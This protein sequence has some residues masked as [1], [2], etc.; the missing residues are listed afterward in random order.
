MID[1]HRLDIQEGLVSPS[2][3][4][5][6]NDRSLVKNLSPELKKERDA[7]INKFFLLE[8]VYRKFG[9]GIENSCLRRDQIKYIRYLGV[10]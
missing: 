1:L 4:Y 9:S 5:E 2:D 7:L 8:H 6:E 3:R 10:K